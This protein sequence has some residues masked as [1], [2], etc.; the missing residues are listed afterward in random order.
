MSE[1]P[2]R[3]RCSNG[4][5]L[6][7]EHTDGKSPGV[8]FFGGFKAD[9]AGTKA[10]TLHAWC[11]ENNIQFTRF[12]YSGHGQSEGSF[13][14]GSI[15]RW[16]SDSLTIFDAVTDGPQVLVGSSMGAWLALHVA[17]RRSERATAVLGIASAADFTEN[18]IWKTLDK[19]QRNFLIEHGQIEQPSSYQ[20]DPYP[21]TLHL[22][23]EARS[24]LLLE[25]EIPVKCPVRLIHGQRDVDVP[26]QISIDIAEK[27]TSNDVQVHLIKDAEHRLSRDKDIQF[28]LARLRDLMAQLNVL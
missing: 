2:S 23:E 20:T 11:S 18:L 27:L 28:I 24:H 5:Q 6:A 4:E 16:L 8:I 25:R 9:M 14:D 13:T 12:D 10:L 19:S 21:I 17:V 22:I 15:G 1:T 3:V 7:Y 26:W